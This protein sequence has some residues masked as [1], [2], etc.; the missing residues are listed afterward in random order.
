MMY[1]GILY[2][3][4]IKLVPLSP[5][6]ELNNHLRYA[7]V[8]EVLAFIVMR[9]FVFRHFMLSSLLRQIVQNI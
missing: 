3:R 1:I 9:E 8:V 6:V 7:V 5:P 4:I 2:R